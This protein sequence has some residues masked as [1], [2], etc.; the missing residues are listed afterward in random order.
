MTI[1]I[2]LTPQY[3]FDLFRRDFLTVFPLLQ[4]S[5]KQAVDKKTDSYDALKGKCPGILS[6][7]SDENTLKNEIIVDYK[8]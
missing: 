5:T 4:S 8:S 2:D 3:R 6:P 1:L 7:F